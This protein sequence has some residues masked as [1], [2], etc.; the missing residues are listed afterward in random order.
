[1]K[2][3]SFYF[4]RMMTW[5]RMFT[6]PAHLRGMSLG[7]LGA[8]IEV[9]IHAS[10]HV[11][12]SSPPHGSRPEPG[13]DQGHT[14][15]TRWD[16]PR[17]DYLGD[18]YSSHVNPAFWSLHAWV[19][20]RIEDWKAANGVF[21][22]DFWK[23]TWV[24]KMP[25]DT[26]EAVATQPPARRARRELREPARRPHAGPRPHRVATGTATLGHENPRAVPPGVHALM[27]GPGHR[28][29]HKDELEELVTVVGECGIFAGG[30][31]S[32]FFPT[33]D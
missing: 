16:D 10:M 20:D 30:Y 1:V 4:N 14:I 15:D 23:G 18:T 11:R 6:D 13:P 3:D 7:R 5:Q 33:I 32:R 8:L 2:S 26:D 22:N 19:D 21:G 25:I 28:H 29:S 27:E 12:W 24:G 9:T 31:A 17:Y